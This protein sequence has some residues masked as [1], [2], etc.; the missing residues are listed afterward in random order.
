MHAH[1]VREGSETLS[2]SKI[3]NYLI[4][5]RVRL[6][7]THSTA[8]PAPRTS[9]NAH[10]Q[11]VCAIVCTVRFLI[12][13]FPLVQRGRHYESCALR[14]EKPATRAPTAQYLLI[15]NIRLKSQN[16]AHYTGVTAAA[17]GWTFYL[18]AV[19]METCRRPAATDG[20]LRRR[21]APRWM[22]D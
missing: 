10:S 5:I 1:S 7:P 9:F 22:L 20:Y 12:F 4:P 21:H 16:L 8:Q 6:G 3:K 2:T 15:T 19:A 18:Q 13:L 11:A 17:A 14:N